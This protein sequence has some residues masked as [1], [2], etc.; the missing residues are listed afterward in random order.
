MAAMVARGKGTR[1]A[2]YLTLVE[3]FG[4]QV[5]PNWHE[6]LIAASGSHLVESVG[7]VVRETYT[8]RYWPGD[9]VGEH[10]EFA[11]KYDGVN[12]AI[13]AGIFDVIGV[14]E[15][16]S[17]VRSKPTGKYARKLWYL[18]E[19]LTDRRLP[20][21]D[22]KVGN[23]VDLLPA[24]SYYTAAP[25]RRSRRH[26]INDNLPGDASF[27]PTI[28]R[29]RR[30]LEFEEADLRQRCRELVAAYPAALLRR[31][32]SYLYTKETKSSF[33][34]EHI[35][36]DGNRTERFVSLLQ[37][38]KREDFLDKSRLTEVQNR[39]VEARFV[40]EDYRSSQNYIGESI[41]WQRERVHFVPPRPED[42]PDLMAGLLR[43][44]ARL[45]H[46]GIDPV[47]HAAAV[48]YGFVFLHPFEDGNGRIHRFLIHNIL[49]RRGYTPEGLIFPV[50]A[51]MLKDP[52]G[53]DD[54][55]EAFSRPLMSLVEY[56][57]DEE[58]RLTVRGDTASLFR[59]ID[60]TPQA[61]ALFSFIERTIETE[62]LG[63]LDFLVN[64][65]RTKAAIQAIVDMPDR[66]IDLFVRFCLQ[67][68][69]RLS[70]RK[71]GS[72]FQFLTEEEISAMEQ[73][74]QDV[75]GEP[76]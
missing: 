57:L 28:R 45:E 21:D 1:S 9:G 48:A 25:A 65:D 50:S 22:L 19:L 27:C 12:L 73:A 8:A 40:E 5:I 46:E 6:S 15:L 58:G 39:I 33:A 10:L 60:L 36:P 67:N 44:H 54:S 75:Y 31:A 24:D 59:Y 38:A 71:Q 69:G 23:Y 61:E 64:Y 29:T 66:R 26:R 68:S 43:S 62:L 70:A 11:L 42:L 56:E 49:A 55:L 52:G 13:L 34:I 14:E 7:G 3:R 16:T 72:H 37:L 4:L 76:Q 30:L 53:Y 18:F 41:A 20:V 51:V 35:E 32:L 74:I 47:I 17:F 63:E 2:G